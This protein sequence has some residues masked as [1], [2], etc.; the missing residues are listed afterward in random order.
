MLRLRRGVLVALIAAVVLWG[1]SVAIFSLGS[2]STA[3]P[4]S[5]EGKIQDIARGYKLEVL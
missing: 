1:R 4:T 2:I 3:P 5:L